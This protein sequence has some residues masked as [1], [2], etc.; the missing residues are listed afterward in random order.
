MFT[1]PCWRTLCFAQML[2]LSVFCNKQERKRRAELV[3]GLRSEMVR[4]RQ[5]HEAEVK[6]LQAELDERLAALQHRHREKVRR[7]LCLAGR[8]D[9]AAWGWP[10]YGDAS[11]R[12]PPSAAQG[13][14]SGR[15][16]FPSFPC[17]SWWQS[18]ARRV[19]NLC[20][21][22]SNS[23]SVCRKENSRIRKTS[24][25]CAQRQ[26]KPDQCSSLAR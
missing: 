24:L 25:K 9:L 10:G 5:L 19:R 6:A 8:C 20:R 26:S 7:T 14:P 1:L 15:S 18:S 13:A 21:S 4:L 23:A 12:L 2:F 16:R 11:V 3:E 22:L 17:P